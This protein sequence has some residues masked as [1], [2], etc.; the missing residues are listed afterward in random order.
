MF[1]RSWLDQSHKYDNDAAVQYLT[2]RHSKQK[3]A[4]FCSEGCIVGMWQLHCE[5]FKCGPWPSCQTR[6]VVGGHTPEMLVTFSLPPRAWRLCHDAC[7]DKKPAVSFEV[8]GG[9]KHSQRMRTPQFYVSGK[10]PIAHIETYA[11]GSW[12]RC[13]RHIFRNAIDYSAVD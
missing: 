13:K 12:Q 2:I 1:P 7:R 3:C 6:K 8:G 9:G 4:Q 5:I 10:R 11:E